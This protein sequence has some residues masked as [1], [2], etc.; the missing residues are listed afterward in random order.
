MGRGRAGAM[1]GRNLS[2][3]PLGTIRTTMWAGQKLK[4]ARTGAPGL[5]RESVRLRLTHDVNKLG[6]WRRA[7]G[8]FFLP[9]RMLRPNILYNIIY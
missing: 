4:L 6:E 2:P 7:L 1:G 8:V 5:T 9:A 3:S